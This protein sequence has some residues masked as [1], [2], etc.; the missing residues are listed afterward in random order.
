MQVHVKPPECLQPKGC[1]QLQFLKEARRITTVTLSEV[2]DHPV[3]Y[4]CPR[5]FLKNEGTQP[6]PG[7]D[8]NKLVR[9]NKADGGD[10][11]SKLRVTHEVRAKYA[12]C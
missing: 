5:M 9:W 4:S 7:Q 12:A 10:K 2:N 3:I 11:C 1:G 6:Y 8:V